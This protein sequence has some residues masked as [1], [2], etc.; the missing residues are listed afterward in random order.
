LDSR[1]SLFKT[2]HHFLRAIWIVELK[3]DLAQAMRIAGQ[4]LK[5]RKL[6]AD[7][8]KLSRLEYPC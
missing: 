8:G 2:A 7:A 6:Y 3:I 1:E 4:L 5:Y